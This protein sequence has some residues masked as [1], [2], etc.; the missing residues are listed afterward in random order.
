MKI[1][2]DWIPDKLLQAIGWTLIH[3]LWQLVLIAGLLWVMLKVLHRSVP[4]T[5]Y[6]IAVGALILSVLATVGTFLY[7]FDFSAPSVG[8]FNE[9]YIS[10][11]S[12]EASSIQQADAGISA[13][14]Q[15]VS[16][17][18]E[19]S[20]PLLVN[21]WILGA[22]LFMFRLLNSL[23]EL[24]GLRN[25]SSEVEDFQMQKMLYRLAGKMGIKGK[26]NLRASSFGASPLTFGAIKPVILFPAGLL[27]QLS[28]AHLEAI[29]AHELAH[30]RRND[31]LANLLLSSLDVI[32]FFHPCYWWMNTTVK[33]LRENA[34]D[35][36]VVKA[37]IEP[38]TLAT[39]LA[40]V[41]NFAKQNPPELALA[42]GKHRNPTLQ[43]I[44]RILGYPAQNYPQTPIISIPMLL[45]LFLSV[46]LMASAQQDAPKYTVPV[47]PRAPIAGIEPT[48]TAPTLPDAIV[49][50]AQQKAKAPHVAS[51]NHIVISKDG[52]KYRIQGNLLIAGSDTVVMSAQALA[53]LDALRDFDEDNMPR[54]DIPV[55]PV[56]SEG[57]APVPDLDFSVDIPAMPAMP[58][59]PIMDIPEF[60]LDVPTP[61]DFGMDLDVLPFHFFGDTTKM[62]KEE[63]EKWAQD[64]EVKAKEWEEKFR[65]DFAPKIKEFELKM[66]EWQAANAPK[67]K[68]FEERMKAWQEQAGPAMEAYQLKISEWEAANAPKMKEFEEKMKLWQE[69]QEPKMK[70]FEA[71]MKEWELAQKPKM[72]EFHRKMEV[73][74]QGHEAKMEEVQKLLQNEL[75]KKEN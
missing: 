43:R 15:A 55:A 18:I 38:K 31:Y 6:A 59:T 34:A 8:V 11:T 14:I 41:L 51:G 47:A 35:D 48:F 63:K 56:F 62:T 68:E 54:L 22:L 27:L 64:I 66:E 23:S 32:F 44:K 39:S 57:F 67:M 5:K 42:A 73:W 24:R 58:P 49:K 21:V 71:K 36:L 16:V 19:D 4:A 40:E 70:E 69:A 28:P 65:R 20:L 74:K 37:G 45:T 26:V 3:S 50:P 10:E 7:E 60:A 52:V 25:S 17:W 61:M 53:A 13:G 75:K 72:D 30:V 12:I 2:I 1:L 9:R 29:L 46:G 33:E